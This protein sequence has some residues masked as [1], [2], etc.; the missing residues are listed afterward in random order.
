MGN[1]PS[2]PQAPSSK[3]PAPAPVCDAEC[4][5]QKNLAGLKLTLDQKAET[6]DTDPNG[7]EQARIAYYTAVNGPGWLQKEKDRIAKKEIEP[8]ISGYVNRYNELTKQNE[9]NKTF[10]GMANAI[11]YQ[12]ATDEEET[13]F[14]NKQYQKAKDK[15]VVLDRLQILNQKPVTTYVEYSGWTTLLYVLI[16]V[17]IIYIGYKFF[18]RPKK[19]LPNS[20]ETTTVSTWKNT[21]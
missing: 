19:I 11:K 6:R 13:N 12:E 9:S 21:S 18:T 16:A 4:Q 20:M 10:V 17:L 14:L 1:Q 3:P 5:K 7:Y 8:V 15:Q 2:A